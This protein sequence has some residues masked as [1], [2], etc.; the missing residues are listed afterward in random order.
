MKL[1]FPKFSKYLLPDRPVSQCQSDETGNRI[2]NIWFWRRLVCRQVS[3]D[4]SVDIYL[5]CRTIHDARPGVWLAPDNILALYKAVQTF[6][7][8]HPHKQNQHGNTDLNILIVKDCIDC[9]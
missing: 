6:I 8:Q 2:V 4:A 1:L 5:T 9:F 7:S 3:Y